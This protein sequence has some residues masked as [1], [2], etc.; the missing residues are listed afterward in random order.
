M[1]AQISTHMHSYSDIY[2][3]INTYAQTQT[4]SLIH[5]FTY[6][7]EPKTSGTV[8]KAFA[9]TVLLSLL[10]QESGEWQEK[11]RLLLLQAGEA[12]QLREQYARLESQYKALAL[13]VAASPEATKAAEVGICMLSFK[14]I[15]LSSKR[16]ET[17]GFNLFKVGSSEG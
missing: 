2:V 13:V 14:K 17:F 12:G 1:H 5:S 16:W 4:N 10:C 9:T 3:C 11:Y 8:T 15:K 7:F 6:S